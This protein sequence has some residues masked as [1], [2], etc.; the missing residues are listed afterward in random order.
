MKDQREEMLIRVMTCSFVFGLFG[1]R[2]DC[3]CMM[4]EGVVGLNYL[5]LLY[6]RYEGNHNACF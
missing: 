5:F 4:D 1:L 3:A 6:C 2:I